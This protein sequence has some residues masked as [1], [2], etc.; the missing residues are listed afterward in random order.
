MH[1]RRRLTYSTVVETAAN[2]V[3][4][5]AHVGAF[6]S[7]PALE[8]GHAVI[9]I[10]PGLVPYTYVH[11]ASSLAVKPRPPSVS[12]DSEVCHIDSTIVYAV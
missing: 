2:A 5:V 10:R 8:I 9:G 1:L 11:R 3:T 12:R 7:I 4:P 6:F